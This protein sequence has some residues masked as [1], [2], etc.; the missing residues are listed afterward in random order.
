MKR[1][2]GDR[3]RKDE[4]TSKNKLKGMGMM[5]GWRET[6]AQLAIG[7][8]LTTSFPLNVYLEG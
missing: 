2:E 6:K 1:K 5:G 4:R 3:L 8:N 7:V